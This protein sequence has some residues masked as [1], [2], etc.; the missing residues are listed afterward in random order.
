MI[1]RGTVTVLALLLAGSSAACGDAPRS[2]APSGP[3]SGDVA[4][5]ASGSPSPVAVAS[6]APAPSRQPRPTPT[7][8]PRLMKW[9]MKPHKIFSGGCTAPVAT[10]DGSGGFHVAAICNGRTRYASSTDGR[11]WDASTLPAS[12]EAYD[13]DLQLAVDDTTLYLAYTHMGPFDADTCG[14]DAG[15]TGVITVH[16]R[17]RALP[18]GRWSAPARIGGEMQHLQSLRVVDGVIHE[19]FDRGYGTSV[20]YASL[21]GSTVHEVEIPE[22][23][24]ASLRIGDDG[25]PRIAYTTGGAVR[26]STFGGGRLSITTVFSENDIEVGS[27]TLVLGGGDHAFVSWAATEIYPHGGGCEDFIPPTPS[28]QGTWFATDANGKWVTKRLTKDVGSAT[29]A[30]DVATGRLHAIY[31]D[32]RGIRYVTRAADGTWSGSR[33]VVPR[34]FAPSVLRRDPATGTLLLVGSRDDEAEA[35]IYSFTAS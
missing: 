26:L 5:I 24:Q 19:A 17:T 23:Q 10:V 22:A 35:G 3:P 21:K 30:V 12:A 2:H 8:R 20:S 29:L 31:R 27:P 11:S 4:L 28:H 1:K 32:S 14:G 13:F 34:D 16:Y 25:R 6:D 15:P 33:L 7:P 18:D 9:S